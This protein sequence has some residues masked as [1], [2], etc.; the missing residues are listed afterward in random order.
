MILK[1]QGGGTTITAHLQSGI[2]SRECLMVKTALR[3]EQGTVA[4]PIDASLTLQLFITWSRAGD[5]LLALDSAHD[6][7][8]G[9]I[10]MT[11][12]TEF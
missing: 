8:K 11:K 6:M 2:G 7:E 5:L 9:S 12:S 10:G 1:V 3:E 4:T